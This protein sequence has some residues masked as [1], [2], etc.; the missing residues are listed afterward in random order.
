MGPFNRFITT[1]ASVTCPDYFPQLSATRTDF[2]PCECSPDS[3]F[4]KP[5]FPYVCK[6]LTLRVFRLL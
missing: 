2:A 5:S 4:R 6:C 1:K 3:Y